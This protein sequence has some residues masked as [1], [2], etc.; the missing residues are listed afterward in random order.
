[1]TTEKFNDNIY[2]ERLR[3]EGTQE[4]TTA[5][6][7]HLVPT[8]NINFNSM[9][10]S[11]IVRY[12]CQQF[13][14]PP[15]KQQVRDWI[16]N[17]ELDLDVSD[18]TI[19]NTIA[20]WRKEH[21]LLNTIELPIVINESNGATKVIEKDNEVV[22]EAIEKVVEDKVKKSLPLWP[23]LLLILP[24]FVAIWS[25]WVGLGE[26]A[27]FGIVHPLPG[28]ADNFKVNSAI[29]LPIGVEAYAGYALFAWLSGRIKSEFIRKYAMISAIFSLI[30]GAIGQIAYHLMTT[31]KITS[32]PWPI[33]IFVS[34]LPILVV[35]MGASLAHMIIRDRDSKE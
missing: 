33:T 20:A 11:D 19:Y 18:G 1:M 27:G 26:M 17:H 22:K 4:M 30:I 23:V 15:S 13:K 10:K 9:S 34:C 29:T 14:V 6:K 3:E 31:M 35:G 2:D 28:I 21:N 32:T 5:E 7:L 25:G 16:D 24:A 8:T 12:V